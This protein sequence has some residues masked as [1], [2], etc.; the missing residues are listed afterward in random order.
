MTAFILTSSDPYT[1]YNIG[2]SRPVALG[3]FIS[4]IETALGQTAKKQLLPMQAGDVHQTWADV[5]KL[6]AAYGYAPKT[7][8]QDGVQQFVAW[9]RNYYK[10][11]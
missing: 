9:Y 7:S 10:L 2:N 8:V 11:S 5:S 4:A 3:A 6:A 1:L